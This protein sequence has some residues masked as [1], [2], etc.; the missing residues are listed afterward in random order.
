MIGA[1]FLEP[2]RIAAR[3]CAALG[4]LLLVLSWPLTGCGSKP[5]VAAA[6]AVDALLE[7]DQPLAAAEALDVCLLQHPDSL[8]LRRLRVMV[9]LRLE[10]HEQALAAL[11][12][13]PAGD[14]AI[15]EA[16]DHPD[17]VIRTGAAKLLAESKFPVACRTLEPALNDPNPNVRRYAATAMGLRPHCSSARQLYRLL[18]DDNSPVRLAAINAFAQRQDPR[19]IRWLIPMLNINDPVYRDTVERALWQLATPASRD[20]L[21]KASAMGNPRWQ[22]GLAMALAKLGDRSVL[23]YLLKTAQAGQTNDRYRAAQVLGSYNDPAVDRVL[24]TLLED[25][26]PSVRSAARAALDCAN[27][28]QTN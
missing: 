9:A 20:T 11:H 23:P 13:L 2:T 17:P 19:A 22:L 12:A 8:R 5:D 10:R 16:L 15:A 18:H 26:E 28:A 3:R 4:L 24:T 7:S 25:H 27:K 1:M 21:V 6:R 14:P